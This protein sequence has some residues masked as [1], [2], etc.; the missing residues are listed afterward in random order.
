VTFWEQ[1]DAYTDSLGTAQLSRSFS[2]GRASAGAKLIY[3]SQWSEVTVT[4]YV[5]LYADYYFTQ[6]SAY[7]PPL[8]LP[9]TDG[10]SARLISGIT[11]STR[12][13]AQFSVGGEFGG[14]G[15]GSFDIWSVRARSAV[16]F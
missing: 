5:G 13:G 1:E 10:A 11:L 15:S 12:R 9:S 4:P 3:H 6:D 8:P 7:V 2:N 16:P 14:L